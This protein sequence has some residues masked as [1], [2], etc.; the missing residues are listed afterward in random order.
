MKAPIPQGLTGSPNYFGLLNNLM[1]LIICENFERNRRDGMCH[2]CLVL[3]WT[4]SYLLLYKAATLQEP[5]NFF[6]PASFK[7]VLSHLEIVSVLTT[8]K[9]FW[10]LAN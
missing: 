8:L 3:S 7:T 1:T 6:I 9:G 10:K 4:D 2:V 5:E